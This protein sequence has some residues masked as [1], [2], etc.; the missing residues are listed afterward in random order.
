M[1]R[2]NAAGRVTAVMLNGNREQDLN[3]AMPIL[4]PTTL[5]ENVTVVSGT[6]LM[7]SDLP[8]ALSATSERIVVDGDAATL[9]VSPSSSPSFLTLTATKDVVIAKKAT[10][11]LQIGGRVGAS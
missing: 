1:L 10:G 5:M 11:D 6:L 4:K 3:V 9:D 2:T 8:G 7:S